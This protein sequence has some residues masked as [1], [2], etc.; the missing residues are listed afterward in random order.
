MKPYKHFLDD[1]GIQ[2]YIENEIIS[3]MENDLDRMNRRD[4]AFYSDSD[5]ATMRDKIS[6]VRRYLAKK[7]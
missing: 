1:A 4:R 6:D 2:G 7:G 3:S 5:R